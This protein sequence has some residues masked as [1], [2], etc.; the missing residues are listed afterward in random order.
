LLGAKIDTLSRL[1]ASF[2]VSISFMCWAFRRRGALL[3]PEGGLHR[4]LY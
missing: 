2:F 1:P 3:G 4:W